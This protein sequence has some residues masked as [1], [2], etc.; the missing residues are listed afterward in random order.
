MTD[1]A[2]PTSSRRLGRR[3]GFGIAIVLAIVGAFVVRL[4]DIQV[5]SAATYNTQAA[6][7]RDGSST[8]Y[9]TRGSILDR[10]GNALATSVERYDFTIS[11]KVALDNEQKYPGTLLPYL[12]QIAS[13]TGQDPNDLMA[14]LE[15]DPTSDYAVLAT[16]LD[17]D[18]YNQITAFKISGLYGVRVP[19]RVYPEGEVAGNLVGFLGTDAPLAGIEYSEDQCLAGT[20]GTVTYQRSRD[21]VPLPGT[22]VVEKPAV[23]GGTVQLTIDRDLQWFT[24]ERTQK[25]QSDLGGTWSATIVVNIK[26]GEILALADEPTLDPNDFQAADP[27]V[28]GSR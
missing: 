23:D 7:K 28:T 10:N 16:G 11:P 13:V 22:D 8:V 17:L 12:K 26:T 5:V 27:S 19:G 20:D 1:R 3:I 25:I 21:G 15:K 9:S 6:A 14:I 18:Q 2:A 4:V 24:Q